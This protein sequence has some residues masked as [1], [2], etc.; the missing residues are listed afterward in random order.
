MS[1]D[2][3]PIGWA[4]LE[5]LG[6]RRLAGYVASGDV[7]GTPFL[8]VTT[9]SGEASVRTLVA[10]QAVYAITPCT[11]ETARAA[12]ASEA[13]RPGPVTPW[14]IAPRSPDREAL[15]SWLVE[16]DRLAWAVGRANGSNSP[17]SNDE[18]K[19]AAILREL[20]N[21]GVPF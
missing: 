21:E 5:L 6:H 15:I 17:R 11:E 12:A 7:A 13:M 16:D 20:R 14:E 2:E 18:I 19:A 3:R 4:V 10:H 1:G 8:D 9:P